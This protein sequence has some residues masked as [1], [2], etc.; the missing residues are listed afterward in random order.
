M[1]KIPEQAGQRTFSDFQWASLSATVFSKW[2]EWL[3][4]IV[5]GIASI[6]TVSKRLPKPGEITDWG[7]SA[8]LV[9]AIAGALHWMYVIQSPLNAKDE[10]EMYEGPKGYH[11]DFPRY[12]AN[13]NPNLGRWDDM[14]VLNAKLG[15]MK[16]VRRALR[17]RANVDH[18]DEEGKTA[19][20]YAILHSKQDRGELFETVM[21]HSPHPAVEGTEDAIFVAAK[22]GAAETVDE[23]LERHPDVRPWQKQDGYTALALAAKAGNEESL[24]SL[25][26]AWMISSGSR[27]HFQE[28]DNNSK[29][30]LM[31][32]LL[33]HQW[34]CA[35]ILLDDLVKS[36]QYDRISDILSELDSMGPEPS[37][38]G[39][40]KMKEQTSFI[41]KNLL[42]P[43]G[44]IKGESETLLH[45]IARR[46]DLDP[47]CIMQTIA[48]LYV[49]NK[50]SLDGVD[51]DG[52]TALLLAAEA[53]RG[54]HIVTLLR[55]GADATRRDHRGR[56]AFSLLME[57]DDVESI[58]AIFELFHREAQSM[59]R[60]LD[61]LG[62]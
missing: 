48:S 47:F 2:V 30:P 26:F 46:E 44:H 53:R 10:G 8:A 41:L 51:E 45:I 9:I 28:Y 33:E 4:T 38:H 16:Y 27:S 61:N 36:R 19:L 3:R 1:K 5:V 12:D 32:A 34:P 43:D 50:Y 25:L 58:H 6:E 7:Q 29:T 55:C 15:I 37:S 39:S 42:E 18:V 20:L 57:T 59:N 11:T 14:L 49:S 13:W 60:L 21:G 40:G 22:F 24:E 56:T 35:R 62:R 31:A 54:D 23:L 52:R 17:H